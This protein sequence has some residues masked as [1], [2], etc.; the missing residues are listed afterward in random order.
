MF[1]VFIFSVSFSIFFSIFPSYT[2]W[3]VRS[4]NLCSLLKLVSVRFSLKLNY[5]RWVTNQLNKELENPFANYVLRPKS[6]CCKITCWGLVIGILLCF[7]IFAYYFTCH[8][9]CTKK[10]SFV[11]CRNLSKICCVNRK[12]IGQCGNTHLLW[13]VWTLHSC[14][15]RCLILKQVNYLFVFDVCTNAAK[16]IPY[17]LRKKIGRML[18]FAHMPCNVTFS[19]CRTENLDV[20]LILGL[21]FLYLICQLQ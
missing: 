1:L 11:E 6:W 19:L 4:M 9:I 20:L 2:C 15:S 5:P 14:S 16:T 18:D 13:L 7:T 21:S 12:V 10:Y 8:F 3:N 17:L